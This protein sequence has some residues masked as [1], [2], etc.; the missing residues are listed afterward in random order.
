MVVPDAQPPHEHWQPGQAV[1]QRKPTRW[2]RWRDA[3]RLGR[4]SLRGRAALDPLGSTV[5]VFGSDRADPGHRN[6]ELARELGRQLGRSGFTVV[7]DGGS[8]IMEAANRGARDV[9]APS[10]AVRGRHQAGG[11]SNAW[12]DSTV[13]LEQRS[14]ARCL[15]LQTC[16][17][18]VILPGGSSTLG[19]A[20]ELADRA[21]QGHP[22]AVPLVLMGMAFWKPLRSLLD[23]AHPTLAG[24]TPAE[25][26]MLVLTDS[27]DEALA[28]I[29]QRAFDRFGNP[30]PS[31]AQRE[32]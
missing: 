30:S 3:V 22:Q 28:A 16:Q 14:L 31:R 19:M 17:G 2:T 24:G 21:E 12:V 26:S 15:L 1:R 27:P 11:R 10:V 20:C 25:P 13:M 18:F 9:Q 23:G 6:Y 5:A 32:R 7:T 8:G 4:A 29:L